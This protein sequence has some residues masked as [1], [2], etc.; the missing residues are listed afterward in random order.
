MDSYRTLQ[1]DLSDASTA[2]VGA[3]FPF[4]FCGVVYQLHTQLLHLRCPQLLRKKYQRRLSAASA[5]TSGANF[6]RFIKFIYSETLDD[7]ELVEDLENLFDILKIADTIKHHALTNVREC[8]FI[9]S[10]SHLIGLP[11]LDMYKYATQ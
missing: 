11:S 4:E 9:L 5:S 7:M 8:F 3:D 2:G 1:K 6:L 10:P